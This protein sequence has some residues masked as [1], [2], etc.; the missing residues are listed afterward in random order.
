MTYPE[1]WCYRCN[2]FSYYENNCFEP[3]NNNGQ[4][5]EQQQ[6]TTLAQ[7]GIQLEQ[8][9]GTHHSIKQSWILLDSCSTDTCTNKKQMVTNL[10]KHK[11]ED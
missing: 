6:G 4:Q 9:K 2:H 3:E 11:F 7:E 1:V 10:Q 8:N 5:V